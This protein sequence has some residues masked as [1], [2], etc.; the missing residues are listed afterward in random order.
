MQLFHVRVHWTR[1]MS[2][3]HRTF[4][5]LCRQRP[6]VRPPCNAANSATR[7]SKPRDRPMMANSLPWSSA[8]PWA[9]DSSPKLPL[10]PPLAIPLNILPPAQTTACPTP[11]ARCSPPYYARWQPSSLLAGG[12]QFAVVC[13]QAPAEWQLPRVTP[14]TLHSISSYDLTFSTLVAMSPLRQIT[15][16]QIKS[17][18]RTVPSSQTKAGHLK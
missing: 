5:P 16:G 18:T 3:P 12:Q 8:K 9:N 1:T 4:Y 7:A 14:A 15:H 6:L 10:P 11:V 13:R 17:K 2:H